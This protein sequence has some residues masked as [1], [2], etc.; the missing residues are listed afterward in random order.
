[1]KI[2]AVIKSEQT[3]EKEISLPYFCKVEDGFFIKV[4]TEE[5]IILVKMHS[6][7]C[8]IILYE[9]LS[10]HSGDISKGQEITETEFNEAYHKALFEIGKYV[11]APEVPKEL[12]SETPY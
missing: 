6:L 4:L 7:W 2:Q 5:R 1:M 9:L 3:I 11:P 10:G 8:Q 12:L